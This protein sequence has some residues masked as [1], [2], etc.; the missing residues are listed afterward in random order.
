MASE[1]FAEFRSR[2]GT[3]T[4]FGPD[5]P[6]PIGEYDG[7][8]AV[9]M[10]RP[11]AT[12]GTPRIRIKMKV[13]NGPHNGKSAWWGRNI[14]PSDTDGLKYLFS[15]ADALGVDWD[16][17][18]D[19]DPGDGMALGEFIAG[20][21]A[22]VRASFK[23]KEGKP[24]KGEVRNEVSFI[25]PLR[26]DAPPPA[27]KADAKA[28]ASGPAKAVSKPSGPPKPKATGGPVDKF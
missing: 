10:C 9:A 8:V 2:V 25:N 20:E 21:I 15:A 1:S 26:K 11:T 17:A 28:M 5:E 19:L 18:N 12:D 3:A 13:D 23:V 4:G 27:Q 22:G 16:K 24:Y 14:D 6:A 7:V